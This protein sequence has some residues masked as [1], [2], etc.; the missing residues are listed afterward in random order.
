[1]HGVIDV[2]TPCSADELADAMAIRKSASLI[3]G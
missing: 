3:F 2:I 1:M